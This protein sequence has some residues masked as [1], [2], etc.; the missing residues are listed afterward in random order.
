MV[1]S[2]EVLQNSENFLTTRGSTADP[3]RTVLSIGLL[4]LLLCNCLVTMCIVDIH[5]LFKSVL[6]SGLWC[7]PHCNCKHSDPS[8]SYCMFHQCHLC[9][10]I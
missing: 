7:C 9:T 1:L 2:C 6:Y 4:L 10:H 8:N 5:T 3:R